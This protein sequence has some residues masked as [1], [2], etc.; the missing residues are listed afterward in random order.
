MDIIN[1]TTFKDTSVVTA[2]G[3]TLGLYTLISTAHGEDVLVTPNGNH[4]D[5]ATA[6]GDD[7]YLAI[8]LQITEAL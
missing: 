8:A 4:I 1:H 6:A 7:A 3:R 5:L 2:R